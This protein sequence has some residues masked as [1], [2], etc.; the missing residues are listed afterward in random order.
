[1]ESW[2][3][4]ALQLVRAVRGPAPALTARLH[5]PAAHLEGSEPSTRRGCARGARWGHACE[6]VTERL[7]GL[8]VRCPGTRTGT[9]EP[10]GD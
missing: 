9:R 7:P 5:L 2:A 6:A 8:R 3:A 10:L 4:G 1:M